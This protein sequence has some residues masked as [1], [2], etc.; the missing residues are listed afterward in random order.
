MKHLI[1]LWLLSAAV[2]CVWMVLPKDRRETVKQ[3][4]GQHVPF[5][6]AGIFVGLGLLVAAFYF[7]STKL[8]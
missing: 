4:A 8:L 7:G 1:T 5:I 3:F 6:L 2:Y